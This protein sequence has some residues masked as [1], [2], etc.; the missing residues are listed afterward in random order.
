MWGKQFLLRYSVVGS[1][2]T[3]FSQEETLDL[4]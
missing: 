2:E 1:E 4:W 3:I